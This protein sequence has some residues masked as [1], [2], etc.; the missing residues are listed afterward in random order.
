M[1]TL[2]GSGV[3]P[4]QSPIPCHSISAV[5]LPGMEGTMLMIHRISRGPPR[6]SNSRPMAI[7]SSTNLEIGEKEQFASQDEKQEWGVQGVRGPRFG[8]R[9]GD[10]QDR[11]CEAELEV[12]EGVAEEQDGHDPR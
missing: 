3:Q 6:R 4:R 10:G 1:E 8:D 12:G 5:R 11:Q 7:T 9:R 2:A